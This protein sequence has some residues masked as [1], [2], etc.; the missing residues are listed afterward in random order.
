MGMIRR[1]L[2]HGNPGL[3]YLPRKLL[4]LFHWYRWAVVSQVCANVLY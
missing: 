4:A 3:P 1:I 2:T